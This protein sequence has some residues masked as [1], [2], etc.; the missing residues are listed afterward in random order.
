MVMDFSH[1]DKNESSSKVAISVRS[2]TIRLKNGTSRC[3]FTSNSSAHTQI[4]SMKSVI[5]SDEVLDAFFIALRINSSR[6][7]HL[8]KLED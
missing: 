7:F 1:I 4:A 2:S 8:K 3:S 6:F 5:E